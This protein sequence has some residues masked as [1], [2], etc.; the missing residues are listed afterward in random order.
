MKT[1]TI[2]RDGDPRLTTKSA[3][4]LGAKLFY[5]LAGRMG[6]TT[7]RGSNAQLPGGPHL[8]LAVLDPV[9]ELNAV[10]V[11][12]MMQHLRAGGALLVVLG[13]HTDVLSDSLHI[14]VEELGAAVIPRLGSTRQCATGFVFTRNGLWL[15]PATLFAL[16][17]PDSLRH[18][19]RTFTFVDMY[20]GTRSDTAG[21]RPST[22]GL[23]VGAG[24]VVVASDPDILRNDAL[25]VCGYGLDIAATDA[26]Q[27]LSG[28]GT[29]ERRTIIFDEFHQRGISRTGMV[30]LMRQYLFEVPSG[31]ALLQLCAA[32]LVLLIAA[33]PRV[34]P[35]REDRRL[36]RRSPL[37]HVDALARAY[38]QVGATRTGALRLVRGMQRRLGRNST[39]AG[40]NRSDEEFLTRI[41]DSKPALAAD[42]ATIRHA[43]HTT[44][45]P[46]QFID[47]GNAIHRVEAALTRT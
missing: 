9:A 36:E 41:A 23:P 21:P 38:A 46:T 42:V 2:G 14:T 12:D 44:V 13:A 47:V 20:G 34:L 17:I 22:V 8:I 37:E 32:G 7:L 18:D 27:Y 35:P 40:A 6:Y 29:T 30:A 25:R 24:R 19:M 33:I 16:K 28:G 3:D 31:R 1:P 43:L 5:E 39:R 4:P 11:H 26:L 45:N 15:G 10:E